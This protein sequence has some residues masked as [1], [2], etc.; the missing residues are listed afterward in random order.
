MNV[1]MARYVEE[2]EEFKSAYQ[3]LVQ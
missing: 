2:A 1:L 3:I